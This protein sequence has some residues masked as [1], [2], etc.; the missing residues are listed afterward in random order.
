MNGSVLCLD[1]FWAHSNINASRRLI[2]LKINGF[3]IEHIRYFAAKTK[4]EFTV[5]L[6]KR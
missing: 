6:G 4:T 3:A 1:V 2:F 5:G